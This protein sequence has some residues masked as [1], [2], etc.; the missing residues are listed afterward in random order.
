MGMMSIVRVLTPE[1]FDE[2]ERLKASG[3]LPAAPVKPAMPP[4]HE[5]HHHPAP[6]P[7]QAP[8]KTGGAK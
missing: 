2:I 6:A 4:G 3:A 7:A 8:K 5:H 1:K